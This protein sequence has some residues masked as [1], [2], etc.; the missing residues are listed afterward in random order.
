MPRTK[1]SS[2]DPTNIKRQ[3][4]KRAAE[5]EVAG[6]KLDKHMSELRLF[7]RDHWDGASAAAMLEFVN[8]SI[9]LEE[10]L[11][12][13]RLVEPSPELERIAKA[14]AR[15][16][17]EVKNLQRDY[18]RYIAMELYND[19]MPAPPVGKDAPDAANE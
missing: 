10:Y 11:T 15:I 7:S 3:L 18:L 19:K 9:K 14:F 12:A 5:N 17:M 8:R 4:E 6:T 2:L 13:R 16:R 1:K